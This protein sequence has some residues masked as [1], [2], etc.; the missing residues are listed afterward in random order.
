MANTTKRAALYVRQSKLLDEGIERQI[1]RT[2]ALATA[3]GWDVAATFEDN[4]V[5][6]SKPRGANTAWG[7]MLAS[8]GD[9][10]VVIGVDLDRVVRSTR[11]INVLIDHGLALVTVDGEIDLASADGEFRATMLAGIARFETRRKAERQVRANEA[12]AAKGL[13]HSA[14][15]LTGYADDGSVDETEA[16][17][18]RSL[19]DDFDKGATI[20]GLA[21]QHGR[22][23]SSIRK[24]LTN[25]RYCGRRVYK[26]MVTTGTWT[27][28][29]SEAQFDRVNRRLGDPSRVGN[30]SGSTARKHLGSGLYLCAE[31]GSRLLAR[32]AHGRIGCPTCGMT[33]SMALVDALVLSLLW[34]RL[35]MPDAREALTDHPDLEPLRERR[36]ALV[37]TR[38]RVLGMLAKGLTDEDEAEAALVEVKAELAAIEE[39][40]A[41]A[42][43]PIAML[44]EQEA[45]AGLD[46]LSL[47]RRRALL[48]RF[49]V[50]RLQRVPKGSRTFDPETVETEW[51][52]A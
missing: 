29:V 51:R 38:K 46:A 26:G 42:E 15:R 2:T 48:D 18:V 4:D 12:R 32:G 45:E 37:E 21:R 34:S 28:L 44:T 20:I 7:R 5:S 1:A 27:P 43:G 3:R 41:R 6:A 50:V 22:G 40:I 30:R 52:T 35:T 24:M 14:R 49:M 19:F 13:A 39:Q 16:A 47:D 31:D 9:I 11:D 36:S 10:D 17:F 23:P 33:R 25:P 8:S